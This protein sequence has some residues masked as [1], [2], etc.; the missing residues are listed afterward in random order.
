MDRVALRWLVACVLGIASGGCAGPRQRLVGYPIAPHRPVAILLDISDQ[1]NAA[2]Q[3]GG[4]ATLADTVSDEL[5]ENGI[6]SQLYTSK[7]DHPPAPRI[8]LNVLYFHGTGR[9]SH[10]FAA[11]SYVVP[12]LGAGALVTAGNQIIVDCQVFLPGQAQPVFKRRF[13]RSGMGLGWS[14]NDDN[15]S[16]SKAG[17][18]IVS[19]VLTR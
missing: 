15:S 3:G 17:S 5:K 6:D 4:V 8:E 12:A 7:Y 11:G 1:V 9:A 14:E 10:Q 2:D 18:E 16:A 19:A 13:N